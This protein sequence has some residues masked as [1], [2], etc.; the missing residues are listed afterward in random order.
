MW[1][2]VPKRYLPKTLSKRDKKKQTSMLAKSR[3]MYKKKQYY[4]R[5]KVSK[6][7]RRHMWPMPAEYIK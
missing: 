7:N 1:L 6:T 5:K 4:T 2:K 3:R